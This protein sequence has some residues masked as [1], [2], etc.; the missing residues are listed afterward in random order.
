MCVAVP[1]KILK[2]EGDSAQVS[3]EGSLLD[4]NISLINKPEIGD[5][6]M[7]H[8]GI[9]I[10]KYEEEDALETLKLLHEITGIMNEE[11]K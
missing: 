3:L 5:Y 2:I 9:A 11:S 10:Q 4:V 6:V 7:I 1:A 8:A